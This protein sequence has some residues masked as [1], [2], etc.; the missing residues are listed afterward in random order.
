MDDDS[1]SSP[2]PYRPR[3]NL[4]STIKTAAFLLAALAVAAVTYAQQASPAASAGSAAIFDVVSP[5]AIIAILLLTMMSG[6]FSASEVAFFGIH[7]VRVRSMQDSPNMAA[8]LVARMLEYPGRLLNTIL[9]GNMIVNVLISVMLPARLIRT[10]ETIAELPATAS[11]LAAA[12]ASTIFLV[13][14]GEILPKIMVVRVGELYAMAVS[15]PLRAI[16]IILF[17]ICRA[18]LRFT[19][20]LFHI[21]RF[22]DIKAAPFITDQEFKSLLARGDTEGVLEAEEGQMIQGILELHDVKLREILVP[23]PDVVAIPADATVEEALTLIREQEFSRMPA[24]DGD[25][26]HIVGILVAKDLLPL[27][28]QGGMDMPIRSTLRQ[29]RF[30]PEIMS[31]QAFIKMAQRV[32]SHLAIVVDEYGGTE[33]IVT[34]EDAIEEVVGE[35][36]DESEEAS[37]PYSKLSGSAYHVDGNIPLDELSELIGVNIEDTEHE[38][39]AGFLMA[40]SNKVLEDGDAI[41]FNGAQF[42]VEEMDGKRVDRL[43]VDVPDEA[44]EVQS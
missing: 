32:K 4:P 16:D 36:H 12:I 42:T 9:V 33:G 28:I 31:I 18:L 13:L 25:L 22:N 43:R 44:G 30:V 5:G 40:Q 37:V 41:V 17:P 1:S 21:T 14:F 27:M 26:D 34:L 35:I 24:F 39:V 3:P 10:F 20:F 19:D 6:F 23:R 15:V 38:T 7:H 8:Q 29:A 11:V 2:E